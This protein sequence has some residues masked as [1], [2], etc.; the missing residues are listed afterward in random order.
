MADTDLAPIV[1]G[2]KDLIA[3]RL[4]PGLGRPKRQKIEYDCSCFPSRMF[5]L[6]NADGVHRADYVKQKKIIF[7]LVS[8]K[9]GRV[10]STPAQAIQ[11]NAYIYFV[12]SMWG[13][14]APHTYFPLS[15]VVL[16]ALLLCA[17]APGIYGGLSD[18][19]KFAW[20][21][22]GTVMSIFCDILESFAIQC[23]YIFSAETT[24]T[25]LC[26]LIIPL[27][28]TAKFAGKLAK[29]SGQLFTL[30]AAGEV[31]GEAVLMYSRYMAIVNSQP[32]WT[33]IAVRD[34]ATSWDEN[35]LSAEEKLMIMGLVVDN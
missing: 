7:E 26:E 29:V 6:A 18:C 4:Q 28:G 23:T 13:L 21:I 5:Q 2:L 11:E 12:K 16:V 22:L 25:R 15:S 20:V 14:I 27:M 33:V 24:R 19:E 35:R 9:L 3:K 32:T 30:V 17:V 31:A 34:S 1:R 10:D 8:K